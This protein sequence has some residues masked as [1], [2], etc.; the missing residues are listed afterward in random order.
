[1]SSNVTVVFLEQAERIQRVSRSPG[2]GPGGLSIGS[3]TLS[4]GDLVGLM[5]G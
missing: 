3:P 1:M 2:P 4:L 5:E